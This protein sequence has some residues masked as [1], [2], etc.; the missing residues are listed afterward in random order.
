MRAA[1][2]SRGKGWAFGPWNSA[3]SVA[4]G[5]SDHG[6]DEPH[7]HDEMFEVYL[8]ARGSATIEVAGTATSL[9]AGSVVVVEP[10]EPHT[11]HDASADYLHF[12]VQTPFVE[13]DK[14]LVN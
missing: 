14:R 2:L 13:G 10:G 12:V 8:V 7:A 6:L 5:F 4:V 9:R 1:V 11:F 3:L